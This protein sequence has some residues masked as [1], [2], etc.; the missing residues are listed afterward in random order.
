MVAIFEAS[1]L[2]LVRLGRII[3]FACPV[4]MDEIT[5]NKDLDPEYLG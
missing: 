2:V 5:F 1:W 3:D 4:G